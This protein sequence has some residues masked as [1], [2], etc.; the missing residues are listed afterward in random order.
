MYRKL[1]KPIVRLL[2]SAMWSR[3]MCW[4]KSKCLTFEG[5]CVCPSST[6]SADTAKRTEFG[7]FAT[8]VG[9]THLL[10]W[11]WGNLF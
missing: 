8:A 4:P 3:F 2:Y 9:P 11:S 7:Q 6:P 10:N 1:T 5:M